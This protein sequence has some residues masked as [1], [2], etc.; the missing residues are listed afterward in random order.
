MGN[1]INFFF[2]SQNVFVLLDLIGSSN[3]RFVCSFPNTCT[4]NKRLRQI[5]NTLQEASSLN[6]V[7]NG[8]ANMFLTNY[9]SSGVADDHVPFLERGISVLHLI[10]TNF[11]PTWHTKNDNGRNL[12]QNSISNFNKIMRVFV[13]DYLTTCADNPKSTG[14][15]FRN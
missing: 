3:A 9:R 13:I 12:N 1:S 11:P 14:C 8:P 4:L 5:E 10:P 2:N 6:R 15:S 7:S